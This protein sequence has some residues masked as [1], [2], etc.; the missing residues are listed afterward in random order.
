MRRRHLGRPRAVSQ[1][2]THG[3]RLRQ[4]LNKPLQAALLPLR[5]RAVAQLRVPRDQ[6][7]RQTGM[8]FLARLLVM[9]P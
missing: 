7:R 2:R 5:P 3:M 1:M 6:V 4:G 8:R 9:L